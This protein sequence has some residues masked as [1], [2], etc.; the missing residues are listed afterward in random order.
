LKK[1]TNPGASKQK[2]GLLD[3]LA[4]KGDSQ[5]SKRGV[6]PRHIVAKIENSR[7]IGKVKEME[8]TPALRATRNQLRKRQTKK[9]KK[10]PYTDSKKARMRFQVRKKSRD[11]AEKDGGSA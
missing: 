4:V 8:D 2:M 3:T 7:R 5:K 6:R 11:F 1:N 10:A 9:E